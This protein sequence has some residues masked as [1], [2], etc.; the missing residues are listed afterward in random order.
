MPTRLR[1]L[2]I[3]RVAVC[4]QGANYDVESG[5]GA[6]I[7][8]FKSA[9]AEAEALDKAERSTAGTNDLPDSAFAYISPG[10]TKD[11]DGKTVPRSLRHLPYKTASGAIDKPHLRNALARL[12]QTDIPASAKASAKRKLRAAAR[13][14]GIDVSD[15]VEKF[16]A[17]MGLHAEPDG[18]ETPP[19]SYA[20]RG[21]QYDL[22]ETLWGKWQCLCET[23]YACVGDCDEDNLPYLPILVESVGQFQDEV[24]DLIDGLGLTAKMAPILA[25]LTSVAKAGAPMAGHRLTRL[26]DAI[27]QLQQILEECTPPTIDRPGVS[28]ADVRSMPGVMKGRAARRPIADTVAKEDPPMATAV[29]KNAESDKEHCD[30]CDDTDCDNPAHDRMKKE[31]L[32]HG[33]AAQM[34]IDALTKRAHEAEDLVLSLR[35]DL[36]KS[37]QEL[38]ALREE[39][40]IAKMS[41]EEQRET[42]LAG[43]PELVRKSYLDQ[44]ARLE[45]IE[46]ANRELHEKNERLDYIAKTAE[47]R[48]LGLTPDHWHVL[49]AVE[50]IADESARTELVRLLK[51]ATEQLKTSSLFG[52]RGVEGHGPSGTDSSGDA[53]GQILALAKAY[54][55]E[56]G[57]PL[58]KGI[59]VIAKSHPELW[60]LNQREKRAKNRVNT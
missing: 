49:K 27:A 58:A 35:A 37:T 17:P 8:L 16:D 60:E 4:Q 33:N 22:W 14:A 57:V 26:Q 46:K 54:A 18:D 7:L 42:L 59:E 3:T 25:D 12:S 41:P 10:G 24:A 30:N 23:Y 53:E 55:E 21:Q 36:A 2:K 45:I 6:H 56:K 20:Q 28:A 48:A 51:A 29:R 43:M 39:Q 50:G 44:E 47:F 15:E 11:E 31:L 5:E 40:R 19:L 52:V 38:T 1:K 34:Q 9:D 13:S 32:V